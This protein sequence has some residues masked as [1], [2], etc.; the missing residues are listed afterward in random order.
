MNEHRCLRARSR[1]RCVR[2]AGHDGNHHCSCGGLYGSND[3]YV[4]MY[5]H[6]LYHV[7]PER[8]GGYVLLAPFTY[9]EWRN[10]ETG[11]LYDEI[12]ARAAYVGEFPDP[13]TTR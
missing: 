7:E 2:V 6:P 4:K 12:A 9:V 3:G 5:P 8:R 11:A 13:R 10:P 1:C